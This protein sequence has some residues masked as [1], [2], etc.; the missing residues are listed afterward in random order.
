[1]LL[2][3]GA[4]SCNS[5]S[6][7][8]AKKKQT[9]AGQGSGS[10]ATPAEG[11]KRKAL[12]R[13][14]RL[15]E[16]VARRPR[17]KSI[18]AEGLRAQPD[19]E[20]KE[21]AGF[22]RW[23]TAQQVKGT[24]GWTG[25][26]DLSAELGLASYPG[27][28]SV[29]LKVTDDVHRPALYA[30]ALG[31]SDH[32]E[33]ELVPMGRGNPGELASRL[34]GVHLR[35][36]SKRQLVDLI[37]GDRRRLKQLAV[38]GVA[39]R[40]GY[41]IEARLPLTTLTPLPAARIARLRY[42]VTIHDSDAADQRAVGTLRF[43]GELKL[44]P[45]MRIHEAV[46]K[47]ASI[48][49]CQATQ[50]DALWGYWHGWRCAVPHLSGQGQEA[51]LSYARVPDPPTV[52]W[53]RERVLFVNLPGKNRGLAA[54]LDH[55]DTILSVMRLGVVGAEDPG[56]PLTRRSGAEVLKLPDGSWAV[57]VVHAL[58]AEAGLG[59]EC[60]SGHQVLLSVLALRHALTSTPHKPAPEP[61]VPPF[62]EEILR[63]VLEDCNQR[64][65]NDWK[66]S[67]DRRTIR[68]HSSLYPTRPASQYVFDRDRYVLSVGEKDSKNDGKDLKKR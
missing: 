64:V 19:G 68:I 55:K 34:V 22:T 58:P 57:A 29:A 12:R 52:V 11:S 37:K 62:L 27:G 36:G 24:T 50:P 10:A 15:P 17:F 26:A 31:K 49:I 65:A 4:G 25:K 67:K 53:I 1:M 23:L 13:G 30:S 20:L 61:P 47:R 42:R 40:G 59:G 60:S 18:P 66:V 33:L 7:S 56:N 28:L 16:E 39:Q 2:A 32:V 9:T 6:P 14:L 43:Q 44:D 45:P 8:V 38:S 54:L 21:W 46:Q 35:L 48:R 63:V 41:R 51:A 3:I 5:A